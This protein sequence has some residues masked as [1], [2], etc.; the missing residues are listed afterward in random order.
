[1][2]PEH[3]RSLRAFLGLS[4]AAFADRVNAANPLLRC[5]RQ[6]VYRWEGG[7]PAHPGRVTTP[8]PHALAALEAIRDAA[9]RAGY[10]VS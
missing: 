9:I 10:R 6:T 4:Q 2:T 3:I 8:N 7:A 1:M 5:N